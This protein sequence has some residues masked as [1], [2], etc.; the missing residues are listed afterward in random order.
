MKRALA[1]FLLVILLAGCFPVAVFAAP[2]GDTNGNGKIDTNDLILIRASV[3]GRMS[4]TTER[5]RRADINGN[6]RIDSNDYLQ[7]R[8]KLLKKTRTAGTSIYGNGT[9]ANMMVGVDE[10]GRTFDFVNGYNTQQVG[11]FFFLLLDQHYYTNEHTGVYDVTKIIANYGLD[12]MFKTASDVSPAGQFHWW[13]EPLW[14]YYRSDD[15][16]VIRKQMELLTVAG[17]DFLVFDTTNAWTYTYVAKVLMKVLSEMMAEGWDTPQIAFYTHSYSMRTVENIY[18]DIYEPNIYPETWY[19]VN[20]K[21]FIVAYT[22][23]SDDRSASG[24]STYNPAPYSDTIANFFTFGYPQW[25]SEQTYENGFAWMEWKYPQPVHGDMINVSIAAHPALPMSASLTK[26]ALNWGR[27]FDMITYKNSSENAVKGTFFDY[28]WKT[29]YDKNPGTVFVTGWN[30]WV[31]IKTW[32]NGEYS[33]IDTAS[34]EFSRDAEMM[35]GGYNDAFFLQL[36]RNIRKFKGVTADAAATTEK[37]VDISADAAQW[38]GVET[39]YQTPMTTN[40]A[41]NSTDPSRTITYTEAAARNNIQVAKVA[42]DADNFYF[43]IQC[44]NDITAYDGSDSWMNLFIGTGT[45][46]RKGWEGYEYVINR[47]GVANG[48]TRVLRLDE[49]GNGTDVGAA[50]YTVQGN[51][52]QIAVPRSVIGMDGGSDTLY[53]KVA[54]RVSDPL[55]I[56]TY[57]TSGKSLPM[58]RLSYRYG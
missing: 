34:M 55:D 40:I 48:V 47:S 31:A 45:V 19:R 26:G 24:D 33:L 25:P 8:M 51:V 22:D 56:M 29:A 10:F 5:F 13:G 49:N 6:G 41:R 18:K 38:N 39:V 37:T 52:M 3:L 44:E 4:M 16:W 9:T 46:S 53:F 7:T 57:Y 43:Y 2:D 35:K 15:E 1:V 50:A 17:V 30:E 27:G 32:Y 12:A 11:L 54:D 36:C 23:P 20:G 28:Q 14:G 58:G 21:P 42:H